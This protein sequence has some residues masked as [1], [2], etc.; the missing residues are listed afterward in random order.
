MTEVVGV[1]GYPGGWVT[2]ALEDGRFA[3]AGAFATFEEV[4]TAHPDAQAIGVDMP[5]GLPTA[6]ERRRADLEAKAF[7]GPRHRSVFT[8]CPLVVLEALTYQAALTRC[9][10]MTGRG[11]SAQAYGLARK[12][13]ELDRIA[14]GRVWE[15]HPEVSFCALAGRPLATGKETYNGLMARL[16][17][18]RSAGIRLPSDL[19]RTGRARADDVLDA[20]VAAWTARR[21]ADGTA[22]SLPHPPERIGD[23]QAAIWY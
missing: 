9:K 22:K 6:P 8:T 5:I 10:E 14:D 16:G 23:R 18:L 12:I 15:V 13:L 2:V 20:A 4:L 19:A 1:D 3:S 17:L 7:V 21:I 11:L